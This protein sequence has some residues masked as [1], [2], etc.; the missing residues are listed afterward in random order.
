VSGGSATVNGLLVISIQ[1]LECK[2]AMP[3][4]LQ[5][6]GLEL[7]GDLGLVS[8]WCM[9]CLWMDWAVA[10]D[11]AEALY[12]HVSVDR[13]DSFV[14][15][16]TPRDSIQVVPVVIYKEPHVSYVRWQRYNERMEEGPI[17]FHL[18]PLVLERCFQY[19]GT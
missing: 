2:C 17:T 3:G 10:T 1:L 6:A 15:I 11:N 7:V 4:L 13:Y 14:T 16:F 8:V 18:K 9:D 12:V 5:G 19:D